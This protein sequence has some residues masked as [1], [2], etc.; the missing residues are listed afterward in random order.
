MGRTAF[1]L[2]RYHLPFVFYQFDLIQGPDDSVVDLFGHVTD[3]TDRVI[4]PTCERI[5]GSVTSAYHSAKS[6]FN[7]AETEAPKP[8][9]VPVQK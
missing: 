8:P 6:L 3:P 1:S 4:G 2:T 5:Y 9:S 7:S